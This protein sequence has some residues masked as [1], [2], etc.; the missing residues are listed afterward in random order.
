MDDL[1]HLRQAI[2]THYTCKVDMKGQNF[3]GF[4]LDWHYKE[5]YVDL[6]MPGYVK[7]AL[8]RLQHIIDIYPQFSPHPYY[9]TNWTKKASGKQPHQL[10]NL[11][12]FRQKRLNTFK[13]LL[14][15]FS[16]M[17]EI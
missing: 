10:K 6:S 2:E 4:T 13:T 8:E 17:Q 3:L 12:Y 15:P 14:E 7:D 5:G 16:A 11:L 1:N 9:H